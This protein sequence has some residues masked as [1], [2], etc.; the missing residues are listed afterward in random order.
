LLCK[1]G[2]KL[3]AEQHIG[4]TSDH[5]KVHRTPDQKPE[6]EKVPAEDLPDFDRDAPDSSRDDAERRRQERGNRGP[7]EEPAFGQGA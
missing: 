6:L 2:G 5:Y 4:R 3:M 7:D 1:F